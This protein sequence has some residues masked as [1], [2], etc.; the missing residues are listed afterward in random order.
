MARRGADRT[1]T[2]TAKSFDSL[3]A[4]FPLTF[5]V[6]YGETDGGDCFDYSWHLIRYVFRL[7]VPASFACLSAAL[8]AEDLGVLRRY[9]QAAQDM[10]TSQFL[11]TDISI[12]FPGPLRSAQVE[13]E[14]PSSES[15]RGFSVLF[16]QFFEPKERASFNAAQRILRRANERKG[17]PNS[18]SRHAIL[19][20]WARAVGKLRAWQLKVLVGRRL[21]QDGLWQQSPGNLFPGE[22]VSPRAV[23]QPIQLW[24][25]HPLGPAQPGP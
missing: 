24:R 1:V 25:G 18:A 17:D 12:S 22:H 16:R 5:P 8:D 4:G 20:D 13:V 19:T 2:L 3:A 23:G 21:V 14:F 9:V 15:I 10:A 6:P 7:P 11:R